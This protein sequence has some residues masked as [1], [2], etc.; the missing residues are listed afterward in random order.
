MQAAR[1]PLMDDPATGERVAPHRRR[2]G[3]MQTITVDVPATW[4]AE[5]ERAA[6]TQAIPLSA[7]L[8]IILRGFLRD[9]YDE[10]TQRSLGLI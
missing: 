8:R 5:L 3:E 2:G 6:Q 4:K 9:R 7:L 10:A 1:V